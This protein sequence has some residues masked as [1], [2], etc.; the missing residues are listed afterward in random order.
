MTGI[1]EL[2]DGLV[3]SWLRARDGVI[4]Q[5]RTLSEDQLCWLP[6]PGARTGI[7]IAR[8]IADAGSGLTEYAAT[9]T[10][11]KPTPVDDPGT[12][13]EV[14]AALEV[15]R[16]EIEARVRSLSEEQ[17]LGKVQAL[18]GGETTRFNFLAFAYAHE[19]YHWGQL[20]LCARAGGE[21]PE[22]TKSI[23]ARR[24]AAAGNSAAG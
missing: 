5:V 15:G 9:G 23:D 3:E 24:K 11:P 21:I 17:L 18:V 12:R 13:A 2:R 4:K 22:L 19:N 1:G 6:G 10:R 14:I 20:G 7:Q 8:H 16:G